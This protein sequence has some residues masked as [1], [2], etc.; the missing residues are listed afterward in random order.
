MS[1]F[2]S[3]TQNLECTPELIGIIKNIYTQADDKK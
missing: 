3:S 1:F 2:S